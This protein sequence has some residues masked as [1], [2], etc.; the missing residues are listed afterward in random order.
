VCVGVCVVCV[1]GVCV[2]VCTGTFEP[3]CIITHRIQNV[4]GY[5]I[6]QLK[7]TSCRLVVSLR[8]ACLTFTIPRSAHTAV[9]MCFVWI[10]EQTAII[11]LYS[12]NCLVFVTETGSVYCTV[13]TGYLNIHLSLREHS[14]L[15]CS[16]SYLNLSEL[17]P[18]L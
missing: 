16:P 2:C 14:T 17:I 7:L 11:S 15:L 9:V 18:F 5:Y 13:R 8:T 12:I 10:W 1:C 4:A 6:Y 3:L